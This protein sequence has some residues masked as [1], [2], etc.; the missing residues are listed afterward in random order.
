MTAPVWGVLLHLSYNMWED[1]SYPEWHDAASPQHHIRHRS[2]SDTIQ[3]NDDL[4]AELTQHM[5]DVG[6]TMVTIDLGDSVA[7]ETRPEIAVEGAWSVH[8]LREELARLRELGLEPLPK[9]NFSTGH[10]AWL[11]EYERAV[12]TPIWY[13]VAADLI[14]EVSELFDSPRFFHLGMDEEVLF[15]QRFQHH[16]VLRQHELWWHDL[17]FLVDQVMRSGV[18]PWVW[19]D[20]AWHAGAAFYQRMPR[21]VLQ[22]NWYYG[23][24]FSGEDTTDRP[25]TLSGEAEHHLTYLD[26]ETHGYDQIPTG[27][28]WESDSNFAMTAGFSERHIAPDRLKGFL[29]TTWHPVLPEFRD[30]HLAAIDQVGRVIEQRQ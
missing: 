23:E 7:Y 22:S 14:A 17:E 26:L 25:R 30:R 15:F 3:C 29:Q 9:L 13:E 20:H 10:D 27:S 6:C 16:V 12:S 1:V 28:T 18:R 5:A 21:S 8:R 4:W 11:H 2:M 19:S 24:V